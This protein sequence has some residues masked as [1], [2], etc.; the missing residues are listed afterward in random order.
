[1]PSHR[2]RVTSGAGCPPDHRRRQ[3]SGIR[4]GA[5]RERRSSRQPLAPTDR[6]NR[7]EGRRPLGADG[8][9]RVGPGRGR[10]STGRAP[11]C[12]PRPALEEPTGER[13]DQ[14]NSRARRVSA[15]DAEQSQQARVEFEHDF[16]P[17]TRI[18]EERRSQCRAVLAMDLLFGETAR[19]RKP[20]RLSVGIDPLVLRLPGLIRHPG[21]HLLRRP[22]PWCV[23]S[24]AADRHRERCESAMDRILIATT[25]PCLE[26]LARRLRRSRSTRAD[27]RRGPIES[28][29]CAACV[30]LAAGRRPM[31][32]ARAGRSR[33]RAWTTRVCSSN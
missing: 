32:R 24:L 30:M 21:C 12:S 11:E 7:I 9:I 17:R 28:Q 1:M 13:G 33:G 29:S 27:V 3:G 19:F 10:R 23:G 22:C 8:R 25:T 20:S 14:R 4:R 5:T 18:V 26:W 6:S 2:N 31:G 16:V 15:T